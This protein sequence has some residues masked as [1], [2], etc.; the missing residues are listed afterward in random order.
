MFIDETVALF[1]YIVQ[2]ILNKGTLSF[3]PEIEYKFVNT[4]NCIDATSIQPRHL[5]ILKGKIEDLNSYI[6]SYCTKRKNFLSQQDIAHFN[7]IAQLNYR[8]LD[9]V[10]KDEFLGIDYWDRLID[11]CIYRPWEWAC[12]N[13][14]LVIGA[15]LL[16]AFCIW[17]FYSPSS[18]GKK[19]EVK[20]YPV[21]RQLGLTCA[22]HSMFNIQALMLGK[23]P[24]ERELFLNDPKALDEFLSRFETT[25]DID[26]EAL[27]AHVNKHIDQTV[28]DRIVVLP[29]MDPLRQDNTVDLLSQFPGTIHLPG[30]LPL[31][32]GQSIG[33]I[34]NTGNQANADGSLKN[35]TK[36]CAHWISVRATRNDNAQNRI[37]FEVTDSIG[38]NRTNH[39][40]VNL[41]ASSILEPSLPPITPPT[42]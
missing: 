28:R 39:E 30:L 23:T 35:T 41:I 13:K 4:Y 25:P 42:P 8:L 37:Q 5:R 6:K 38:S 16:T 11:N 20:Q 3:N 32:E 10:L 27:V 14:R 17:Y 40:A 15:S 31:G 12:K 19:F 34:V 1:K 29:S 26:Q 33:F 18:F 22:Y 9:W 36:G 21:I 24:E 7:A 2:E